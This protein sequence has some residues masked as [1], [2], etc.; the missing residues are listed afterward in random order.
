V[1]VFSRFVEENV[2]KFGRVV[3]DAYPNPPRIDGIED[4]WGEF[5]TRANQVIGELYNG[6]AR[7][8]TEKELLT[9][10]ENPANRG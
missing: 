3:E 4:A 1:K 9:K 2:E 5:K 7:T 6:L 10:K 8:V